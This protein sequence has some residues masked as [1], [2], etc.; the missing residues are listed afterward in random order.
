VILLGA[1][2]EPLPAVTVLAAYYGVILIH[3]RGHMIAAQHKG[4]GVWS[5]ELYTIWGITRFSKPYSYFDR[6][7]IAW[8]DVVARAIVA[9]PLLIWAETS[10]T[11][12]FKR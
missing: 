10:A 8:G 9:V 6:C 4:C 1:L 2:E 11:R 12:A 5:I 7:V 3:E